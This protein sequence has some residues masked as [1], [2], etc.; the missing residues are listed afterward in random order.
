MGQLVSHCLPKAEL[1]GDTGVAARAAET[2]P[3]TMM[4]TSPKIVA[5]A[6][7]QYLGDMARQTAAGNHGG[8]QRQR[9]METHILELGA[10]VVEASVVVPCSTNQPFF[11]LR[12]FRSVNM[13]GDTER[14]RR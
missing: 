3:L 4:Q 1:D 13:D 12:R 6:T 10:G 11:L 2:R 14:S 8:C 9:P 5:L 7:N